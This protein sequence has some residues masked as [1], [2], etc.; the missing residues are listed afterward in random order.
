MI[1]QILPVAGSA[2]TATIQ[3]D[4]TALPLRFSADVAHS[5]HGT[6][7]TRA[8]GQLASVHAGRER[9]GRGGRLPMVC[10]LLGDAYASLKS[11]CSANGRV[12]LGVFTRT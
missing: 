10:S 4:S 5:R 7:L 9:R 8:S 2:L 11:R 1:R 12:I 3:D 6:E